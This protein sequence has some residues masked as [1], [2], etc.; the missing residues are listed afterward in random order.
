MAS[1]AESRQIRHAANNPSWLQ[2]SPIGTPNGF[3]CDQGTCM[4]ATD[5]RLVVCRTYVA[6]PYNS[7]MCE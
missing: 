5:Q 6:L 7:G 1:G 4:G 3:D 2:T